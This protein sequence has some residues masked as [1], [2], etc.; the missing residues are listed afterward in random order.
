[1]LGHKT[2]DEWVEIFEK[3]DDSTYELSPGERVVFDPMHGFF[4]YWFNPES[5]NIIIPKMC[6]DI[7]HWYPKITK[8]Y[9]AT[10]QLG[11]KGVLFCT[12]RN[13]YAFMRLVGGVL[14]SVEYT[15]D[16]ETKNAR[17]IWFISITGENYNKEA[18][19]RWAVNLNNKQ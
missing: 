5:L 6:G 14:K 2:F 8:L 3:K 11:I 18:A 10:K 4:S 19:D 15:Y 9:F 7:K 17:T 13:P 12:K 1:M 16:F